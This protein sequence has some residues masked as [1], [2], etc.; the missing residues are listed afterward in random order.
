MAEVGN[1]SIPGLVRSSGNAHR[2]TE[3]SDAVYCLEEVRPPFQ[4]ES[5]FDQ[6][7]CEF[8]QDDSIK[9]FSKY[10]LFVLFSSCIGKFNSSVPTEPGQDVAS[11]FSPSIEMQEVASSFRSFELFH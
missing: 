9:N 3:I 10:I 5:G 4:S 2:R 6:C 8:F 1:I 11:I 7:R